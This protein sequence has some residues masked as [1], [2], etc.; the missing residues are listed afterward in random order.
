MDAALSSSP[1]RIGLVSPAWPGSNTPNGI[2]TAVAHLAAGLES[3]GHEVTIIPFSVDAAHDFP[4]V[5]CVPEQRWRL[6]DRIQIRLGWDR[7]GVVQR[8][9]A[10]RIAAAVQEAIALHGIEI[11]VMEETQGWASTIGRHVPIPIVVTLHGPW[12]LHKAFQ[13][14]GSVAE[15]DRRERREAEG[16]R[17][18]SA[19]TAP[20]SDVLDRTREKWGVPSVPLAVLRNP[21]PLETEVPSFDPSRLE[22]VLFVGR[23]ELVKGGDVVLEAFAEIARRHPSCRLTFVG[24]DKGIERP[25]LA[26][27]TLT[28]ALSRLPGDVRAR[29]DVRGQCSRAEV[30]ALRWTHGITIVASRYENFGGT[31]LEAMAAGSALVCTR[32]GGGAEILSDGETALLIPPEDPQA[33]ADACLRLINDP[34]LARRMGEAARSYVE[35][36]LSPEVIGRQMADFLMP[37]RRG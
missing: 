17:R 11:L 4:R 37:L 20:S 34:G 23:F 13:P 9:V 30:A 10:R 16:L 26:P 29:I 18:A 14:P 32:V 25:G 3:H 7:E 2:A 36:H 6:S 33:L 19:I 12:W 8:N 24:P 15:S 27:L 28:E 22:H 35:S 21:M 1:L 5:V 31:I